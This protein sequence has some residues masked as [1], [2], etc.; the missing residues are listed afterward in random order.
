MP[1]AILDER[2]I[3]RNVEA[4]DPVRL[5]SMRFPDALHRGVAHAGDRRQQRPGAPLVG[6]YCSRRPPAIWASI[7]L[8]SQA[9]RAPA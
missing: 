9:L 3:T 4:L 6:R 1:S 5:E 2:G 8:N 7:C